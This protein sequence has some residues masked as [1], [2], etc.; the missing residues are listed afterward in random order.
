VTLPIPGH[1]EIAKDALRSL[2]RAAGI[3]V[4]EFTHAL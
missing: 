2:I 3:T 1:K 4:D